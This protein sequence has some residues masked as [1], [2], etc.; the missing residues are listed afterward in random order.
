MGLVLIAD[1]LGIDRKNPEGRTK[2]RFPNFL[3][4]RTPITDAQ[5]PDL[6]GFCLKE[7]LKFYES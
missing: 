2:A 6:R 1:R 3:L 5:T 4:S 7:S